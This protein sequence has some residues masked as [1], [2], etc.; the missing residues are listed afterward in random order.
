[1]CLEFRRVLFRS[2]GDT[3]SVIPNKTYSLSLY[4]ANFQVVSKKE[5]TTNEFGSFTTDFILPSACLNGRF[6]LGTDNGSIN[7]Q[8]EDYKLPTFEVILD[9]P[10][11]SYNLGD[12]VDL[13]GN[14]K[15][16]NGVELQEVPVT[17][18]VSLC[19]NTW[20]LPNW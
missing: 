12:T 6:R 17:Y 16:L 11:V 1:M 13:I 9:V 20:W 15:S 18:T 5:L 7:I 3:A 19:V 2:Q 10:T 14:A 4:D 8:V